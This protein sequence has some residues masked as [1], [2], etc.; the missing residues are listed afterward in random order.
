MYV[1]HASPALSH[2]LF[3][4]SL[5]VLLIS[6]LPFPLLY[7]LSVLNTS[8]SPSPSFDTIRLHLTLHSHSLF[9]SLFSV[10]KSLNIVNLFF[11]NAGV[12]FDHQ[13]VGADRPVSEERWWEFDVMRCD[14][15]SCHVVPTSITL[16]YLFIIQSYLALLSDHS[17]STSTTLWFLSQCRTLPPLHN[18]HSHYS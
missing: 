14:A 9:S 18:P 10:I 13:T 1:C 12:W 2:Y 11:L 4:H 17:L 5:P 7:D 8:P 16:L 6:S 15:V 3:L